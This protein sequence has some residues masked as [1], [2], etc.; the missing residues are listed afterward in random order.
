M[1]LTVLFIARL[2]ANQYDGRGLGPFAKDCLTCVLV[3]IAR[4]A[5][6]NRGSKHGKALEFGL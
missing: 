1:T 5:V 3:E 4:T 6:L 2:F